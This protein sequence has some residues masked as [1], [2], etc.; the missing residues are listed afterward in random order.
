[1]A[2]VVRMSLREV[3][4]YAVLQQAVL[5]RMSQS[6]AALWLN[7]SVRQ[8]KRLVRAV[9]QQGPQGV[10]SK[11]RGAPSNRRT[12]AALRQRFVGLVRERYSDFGPTLACEHLAEHHGYGGSA[13]TLRGWMIEEGL[14]RPKRARV[15]RIHSPGASGA[16][17]W[18]SWCR[19]TAARTLGSKVVPPS[20]A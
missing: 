11:R 6:D 9:R 8:I 7:V 10:V 15:G 14:W 20:A 18:A 1:M 17:A 13:Q 19:S 3:D 2:G 16:A 12:D 5:R 4:R